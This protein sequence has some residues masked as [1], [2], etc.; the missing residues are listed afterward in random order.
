MNIEP[1]QKVL[2]TG[3]VE[4]AY[5]IAALAE[6]AYAQ[7]ASL[8]ETFYFDDRVLAAQAGGAPTA[9][10]AAAMPGWYEAMYQ[11]VIDERWARIRTL[12]DPLDDP[13]AGCPAG[14]RHRAADGGLGA[15][16][17]HDPG[18]YQLE[19]VRLP[20]AGLGAAHLRRARRRAAVARP[21]LRRAPR[22]GR[23]DR[24]L[25]RPPRRAA[26]R[27]RRGSTRAASWRLRFRGGGTDLFVPLHADAR[28]QPAWLTTSWG[29][30]FLCNLPSEEIYVTPDFRGVTG[31][32]VATRPVTVNG[33]LVSGLVV[34]FADGRVVDVARRLERGAVRAS[35]DEDRGARRL[36]EVAL[37]DS[38]SRVG[39][40][41]IVFK[42]TLL[43][44]NAACHIAW[45]AAIHDSFPDGLPGDDA[46]LE[47]RGVN[48][49]DVHQDVMIGG[50][51]V[52]VRGLTAAGDERA[53][54]GRGALGDLAAA[55]GSPPPARALSLAALSSARG[56]PGCGTACGAARRTGRRPASSSSWRPRSTMR[57]PRAP[58]SGR[59]RAPSRDG[60]R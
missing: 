23:P 33:V 37:V 20:D 26:A 10:L 6:R 4:H 18:A 16:L 3:D 46:A 34:R 54:A 9:A 53:G 27:G 12:G 24:R 5:L 32:A 13:Y 31:T 40:L 30:R 1:G 43:D 36:G 21:A 48:E 49:S 45:G 41:G 50:P 47:A 17:S 60:G 19:P 14:A 22:R 59:R 28:W 56:A 15:R 8:A 25:E 57:P 35:L 7:G 11:T 44:E 29:R 52:T 38:S 58:G 42:E 2:I 51:E 55:A 39:R